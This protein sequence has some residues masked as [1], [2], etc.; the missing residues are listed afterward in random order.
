MSH[1]I[2]A[3]SARIHY[4]ALGSGGDP[5]LLLSGQSLDH[6]M[7]AGVDTA[8][9]RRHRVI[10][11]DARGTGGSDTP[12]PPDG[13]AGYTTRLF[14]D[15]ALAVLDALG[16]GRAH[17]YG[18]SMGGRV[19]QVLAAMAPERVGALVLG[20]TGPG[21]TLE[22]ARP[23]EATRALR[24]AASP[25][26]RDAVADLFFTPAWGG[27]HPGIVASILPANTR[28]AQRLHYAASSGHDAEGLLGA[29]RAPTLVLHGGD[30]LLTPAANAG[31]LADRIPGARVHIFPGAR[32]GYLHEARPEAD[33]AVL[34]FLAAHPLAAAP[35]GVP[36]A[37]SP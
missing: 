26:G 18:F 14:A 23:P 32:H 7:W 9:A 15:D 24:R 25:E 8:L 17:V 36:E 3:D 28:H 2:A 1:A 5:L 10:L 30:D 31:I 22:A 21:G 37:L 19:A 6:R 12:E 11:L 13:A 16:I 35:P 20:S 27:A 4:T 33:G 34:D 29:I